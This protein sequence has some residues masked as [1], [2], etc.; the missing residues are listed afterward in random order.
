MSR[1]RRV[2]KFLIF[3]EG[4][5]MNKLIIL[6]MNLLCVN[7]LSLKYPQFDINICVASNT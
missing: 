3:Y 7:N 5:F 1:Q 4:N 6:S 2:K